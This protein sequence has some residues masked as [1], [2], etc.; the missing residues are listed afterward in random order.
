[1]SGYWEVV[2]VN[3]WISTMDEKSKQ[4]AYI[5]VVAGAMR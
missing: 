5:C 4:R 3:N 2:Q 1:M